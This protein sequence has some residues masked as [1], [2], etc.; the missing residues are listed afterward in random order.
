MVLVWS[1][2]LLSLRYS[3]QICIQVLFLFLMV[4]KKFDDFLE[5]CSVR[6]VDHASDW[7]AVSFVMFVQFLF[8]SNQQFSPVVTQAV[9]VY[10]Q[11][12]RLTT[13]VGFWF[14]I[15]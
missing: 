15:C 12:V 9:I 14:W 4:L 2:V 7:L 3:V 13:L 8:S 11:L 10:T 5:M 1:S 6:P